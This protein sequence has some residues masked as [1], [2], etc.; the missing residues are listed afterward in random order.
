MAICADSY[1]LPP[2]IIF[3]DQIYIAGCFESSNLP[4]DCRIEVSNNGWTTDKIDLRWLQKIFIPYTNLHIQEQFRLLI[5]DRHSSYLISQFDQI[6]TEHNIILL[7]MS[8][9]LSHLLQLLNIGYFAVLKC[10][11]SRFVNDLAR[12]DYNYI[13]KLDFL[14]D[15]LY[16][17]IEAFQSNIIQS[18]FAA[19]GIVPV[20]AERVLSKLNISL[21]T[22]SPLL[23]R[24]SSKSSQFTPKTPRTVIQLEKQTSML[25][26]LYKQLSKSPPTP[27]KTII[28]QII[29]GCAMTMHSAALFAKENA[30]LRAAN[31]KKYQKR[32]RSTMRIAHEGGLSIE[33]GLQL[34]QQP[35]QPAEANEIVSHRMNRAIYLLSRISHA[36]G[37]CLSV[38]DTGKLD[39]GLIIVINDRYS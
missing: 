35:I 39:I 30:D 17:R 9:Y 4:R 15:Y 24:P 29:K 32:T 5:L 19:T 22:P 10:V 37:I 26:E 18:S 7:C 20:S 12:T 25:K 16:T 34:V 8:S 14:A 21:R 28:N 23:S 36:G 13:D 6:Y 2:C 3:K 31:E 33:E 11:Y 27:S 38:V 1:T